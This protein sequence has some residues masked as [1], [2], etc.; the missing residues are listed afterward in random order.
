MH[1][2]HAFAHGRVQ[3]VGFRSFVAGRARHLGLTGWVHNRPDGS[4]EFVAEGTRSALETLMEAV[5]RGPPGARVANVDEQW[6]EGT[7][8]HR[9]FAVTG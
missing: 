1:R 3:G 7:P 6:S 9:N 4:V 5:R 8:E 2:V